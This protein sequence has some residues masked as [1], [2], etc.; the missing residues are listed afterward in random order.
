MAVDFKHIAE[1]CKKIMSSPEDHLSE[2]KD[3][4]RDIGR[5]EDDNKI[6]FIAILKVFKAVIPLYKVRTLKDKIIHKNDNLEVQDFDKLILNCYS[7]YIAKI[8]GNETSIAYKCAVDLLENF[9]H[10]NYI[11]RVVKKVLKGTLKQPSIS[12]PCSEAI[13]KKLL[14]DVKGEVT[15]VIVNQMF[16]CEFT[17]DI[18]SYLL[19]ITF[20]KDF[21]KEGTIEDEPPR[22]KKDKFFKVERSH[23]KKKRKM[24]KERRIAENI[25]REE[26]AKE[27]KRNVYVFH[28]KIVDALQRLYFLILRDKKKEKFKWTFIGIQKYKKFIRKEFLEGL[29]VL[30]N[31][32]IAIADLESKLHGVITTLEIYA[33]YK[34][35]FK[36]LIDAVYTILCP[37]N[38]S[39]KKEHLPLLDNTLESLFVNY[40]QPIQRVNAVTHRLIIL[41]CLRYSVEIK[42]MIKNLSTV[43]ELDLTDWFLYKEDETNEIDNFRNYPFC[44]YFLFK[45]ML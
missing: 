23:D 25:V 35:D 4:I 40:K 43:Y 14:E 37:F 7:L 44:D 41:G 30:L 34:Y 26:T 17:P 39:L 3:I 19:E 16:E 18:L 11:D 12:I 15:F 36:R 13:Q 28:R 32:A 10:F 22:E 31:D 20:L 5:N 29:Y 9:D 6:L 2:L 8:L 21:L 45:K 27:E 42:K 33:Q 38:Y 24:E 1:K